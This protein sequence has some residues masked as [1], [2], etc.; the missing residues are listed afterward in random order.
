MKKFLAVVYALLAY[1][2]F[3]ITLAYTIL[4]AGNM[5]VPKSIDSGSRGAPLTAGIVDFGLLGLFAIQHSVMARQGFKKVWTRVVHPLLERSTYVLIASL[6]LDL[7]FWQWR[8]IDS[9]VWKIEAPSAW[10]AVKAAFWAGWAIVV[11]HNVLMGFGTFAV[12]QA[13][14]YATGCPVQAM[15]FRTP[16]LYRVVRHPVYLGF[17]TAFW[18]APLMTAGHLLFSVA[19]TAYIFVG[20]YFEERDLI[21]FHGDQYAEYRRRVAMIIPFLKRR[22]QMKPEPKPLPAADVWEATKV[23]G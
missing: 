9:V 17:I 19:T 4:F 7:L 11:V 12:R 22:K 14:S 10:A 21:A 5:V 20:I 6:M 8:R 3:L 15:V 23:S 18:A 16:A 1:L 2:L 13:I